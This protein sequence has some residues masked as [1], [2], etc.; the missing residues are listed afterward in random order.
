MDAG[1]EP[2][3]IFHLATFTLRFNR[4]DPIVITLYQ[5]KTLLNGCEWTEFSI[6]N[7]DDKKFWFFDFSFII[8]NIFGLLI[9]IYFN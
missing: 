4:A 2:E 6:L 9:H 5:F 1:L 3:Q 8:I 7:D